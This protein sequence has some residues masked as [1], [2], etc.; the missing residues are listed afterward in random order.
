[1]K[2]RGEGKGGGVQFIAVKIFWTPSSVA[3]KNKGRGGG[4]IS[5]PKYY[6]A[7][8][9]GRDIIL[10]FLVISKDSSKL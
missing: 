1:M 10:A 4:G 9:F 7:G 8:Y 6:R 2:M 3:M 5:R